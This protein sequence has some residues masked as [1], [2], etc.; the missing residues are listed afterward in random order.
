MDLDKKAEEEIRKIA[1]KNAIDYGSSREGAVISK[2]LFKFPGLKT[3][4]LSLSLEVRRIVKE[5]NKMSRE[6]LQKASERYSKEFQK[7]EK[8]RL[9]RTSKPN[10]VIRGAVEGSVV[11]R[12]APAPN[13][14]MHI[15]NAKSAFLSSELAKAYKGKVLLYFDD[16]NPEKDKQEFVDMMKSD[17]KW[18]GMSF[19]DEYYASDNIEDIYK[20][21][22]SLI[23]NNKAYACACASEE[24]EKNR[25]KGIE[26]RHRKNSIDEN[27][28]IFE[29][30]LQGNYSENGVVIRL[31]AD[32]KSQNTVLR[33][34]TLLRVK[35]NKHY[36]HGSKYFVWPNYDFNTPIMDY[37]KGVTDVIRSKEYELRDELYILILDLLNLRKPRLHIIAR[38]EIEGN[39]TS[40]RKINELVK[41]KLI[42]GYDDPRLVTIAGLRRRGISPLAVK[43]FVLR[44][45]LSK[46]ESKVKINMLLDY[47]RKLMD[48]EAKRLFF[49]EKPIEISV[50]GIPKEFSEIKMK[51]HPGKDLGYRRYKI[52][53]RFFINTYDANKLEKGTGLRLKDGFNIKVVDIM[54]PNQIQA[55]FISNESIEAPK[56][57]WVSEGNYLEC[58]VHLLGDL[59]KG[60]EFNR[61]SLK[62][63]EGYVESYA[64][65]LHE[66][67]VVQFERIGLFKLDNKK[68][69]LF[70]SL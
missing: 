16:T 24:T 41:Q 19:D 54:N 59:L 14:Y 27:S 21:A 8:E 36:R 53:N 23:K 48:D 9:E 29:G 12:Y 57:Q 50:K 56:V 45:G 10:M 46:A 65:K 22:R 1:L 32:M 61:E 55:E 52:N 6:E 26:C 5:T 70:V 40:K 58:K 28:E 31:R 34:P 67:E 62:E 4:M 60:E 3:D 37:I 51:L 13:G 17:L 66:N 11:T 30:M 25:F 68:E 39:V 44:F 42:S 63:I 33:D 49:V 35:K 7:E 43:E 15:G 20:Y 18:L 2:I 64:D 38:L 47:N 69:L